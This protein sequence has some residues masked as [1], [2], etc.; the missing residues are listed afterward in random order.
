VEEG[1]TS[2]ANVAV[3]VVAGSLRQTKPGWHG[4]AKHAQNIIEEEFHPGLAKNKRD[5]EYLKNESSVRQTKKQHWSRIHQIS[6]AKD[7]AFG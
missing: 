4:P 3:T 2:A 7:Q 5:V 6:R 1:S